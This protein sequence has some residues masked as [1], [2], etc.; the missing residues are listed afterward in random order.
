MNKILAKI[1]IKLFTIGLITGLLI[2]YAFGLQPALIAGI[3]GTLINFVNMKG[4]YPKR[5]L[6]RTFFIVLAI[7]IGVILV[8]WS[9]LGIIYTTIITFLFVFWVTFFS[10]EEEIDGVM[11][12]LPILI[13]FFI[14][15]STANNGSLNLLS[16]ILGLTLGIF[17]TQILGIFFLKDNLDFFMKLKIKNY[18]EKCLVEIKAMENGENTELLII[19]TREAYKDFLK[20]FYKTSHNND[21]SNSLGDKLFEFFLFFHSF[22]EDIRSRRLTEVEKNTKKFSKILEKILNFDSTKNYNFENLPK[23]KEIEK[24]ILE[25]HQES[26]KTSGITINLNSKYKNFSLDTLVFRYS[27]KMAILLSLGVYLSYIIH[28][29]QALWLPIAMMV[30]IMPY[31][32]ESHKKIVDRILGTLAGI[33]GAA[34]LIPV[35]HDP[36][37]ILIV[38]FLSVLIGL[39]FIMSDIVIGILFFTLSVLMANVFFYPPTE[40]YFKRGFYVILGTLIVFFY[41]LIMTDRNNKILNK[42]INRLIQNDL[43]V[44]VGIKKVYLGEKIN[45][46]QLFKNSYIFRDLLEKKL[47]HYTL[48]ENNKK[49]LHF[50]FIFIEKSIEIYALIKEGKLEDNLL[51]EFETMEMIFRRYL[52]ILDKSEDDIFYKNLEKIKNSPPKNPKVYNLLIEIDNFFNDLILEK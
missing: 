47:E 19:H 1:T 38:V 52:N 2:F 11:V 35:L 23:Y 46:N 26:K 30:V 33:G 13:I 3:G 8:D 36:L 27:L 48:N 44:L 12:H 41:E 9:H 45:M 28:S 49:I 14:S 22:M 37:H 39:Y 50:S 25:R 24:I 34:V 10:L 21:I 32:Q 4:F 40:L 7:N 18:L 31:G 43:E 42:E 29:K 51:E 6:R 5:R 17:I 15:M 16:T 20:E